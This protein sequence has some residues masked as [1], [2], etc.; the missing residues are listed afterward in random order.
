[1]IKETVQVVDASLMRTTRGSAGLQTQLTG[2][3][4][5]VSNLSASTGGIGRGLFV[6]RDTK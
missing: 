4:A 5:T 6:E 2:A 3:A 1:M